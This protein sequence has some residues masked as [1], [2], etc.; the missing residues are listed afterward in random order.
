MKLTLAMIVRDEEAN[1]PG[2]LESARG[3]W[4]ELVAVDTG[5]KD[6]TVALLERAGAKVLHHAWSDDFAAAR[7]VGL[8][9]AT[10]DWIVV[11]DADERPSPELVAAIRGLLHRKD[12][13][14]ATV[15]LVNPLQNGHVRE[16]PLLRAFR[17]DD[18]IRFRFAIHED[19][20]ESVAQ[21]LARTKTQLVSL[22]GTVLHLGYQRTVARQRNKRERDERLL[23]AQVGAHPSDLYSWFKLL[24]LAAF[25]SDTSLSREAAAGALS[26]MTRLGT[27]SLRRLH[28]VGELLALLTRTLH[29]DAKGACAFL[30]DFADVVAHSP[31]LLYERGS[32]RELLGQYANAAR[33]FSR[34]L[35]LGGAHGRLQLTS[36]RPLM[37]LA[38]VALAC[39]DRLGA[40]KLVDAALA[41]HPRDPEALLAS[42]ADAVLGGE[43]TEAWVKRRTEREGPRP[44]LWSTAAEL[45]LLRGRAREAVHYFQR[46]GA[47]T[48]GG[49]GDWPRFAQALLC[50]G[51]VAACEQL[52]RDNADERGP[53]EAGLLLCA[54]ANGTPPARCERSTTPQRALESWHA[55]LE[56]CGRN[57][58]AFALARWRTTSKEGA[59][60]AFREGAR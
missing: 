17:N 18:T 52:C 48:P 58:L 53:S 29:P 41:G 60:A 5:S 20:T 6:G 55:A 32:R 16:T 42:A 7:N 26:A 15:N 43:T 22:P 50:A 10:G 51:E 23:R 8:E 38:R 49:T 14:A 34:G 31:V 4:D 44:E 28:Y 19:V 27:E 57:D 11:L 37:G 24:E 33:D 1:L 46:A 25:W 3:L 59:P 56:A 13:G 47:G 45:A 12:A 30:D 36:V 40:R 21:Y 35:A 54:L 39:G 2:L 9:A